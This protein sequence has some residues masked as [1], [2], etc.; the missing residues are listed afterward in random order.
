MLKSR[1]PNFIDTTYP[2]NE[3]ALGPA[4]RGMVN[5]WSR[6]SQIAK[7]PVLGKYIDPNDIK[8]GRF[9]SPEFL[10]TLSCLA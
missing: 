7:K 4:L 5:S 9:S 2:P 10:S 1:V 8:A 3:R 6:A